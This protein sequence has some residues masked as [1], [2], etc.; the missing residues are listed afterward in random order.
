MIG[1]GHR[2][3]LGTES[4]SSPPAA[5]STTPAIPYAYSGSCS[6]V[7][8]AT[9]CTRPG[10]MHPR[11]RV[12]SDGP[13]SA[14]PGP[15]PGLTA[16]AIPA[17]DSLWIASVLASTCA[18]ARTAVRVRLGLAV[19]H[20][21]LE[22]RWRWRVLRLSAWPV[23]RCQAEPFRNGPFRQRQDPASSPASSAPR[24]GISMGGATCLNARRRWV[25]DCACLIND[26]GADGPQGCPRRQVVVTAQ[27][28]IN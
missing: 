1:T 2:G 11:L 9:R 23:L 7:K 15:G 10:N 24:R 6:C 13:G 5:A 18:D 26:C 21:L 14:G 16:P 19:A 8:T 17:V 20:R 27:Q 3:L 4:R 12:T 28:E 22:C 25:H